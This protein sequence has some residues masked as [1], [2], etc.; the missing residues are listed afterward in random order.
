MVGTEDVT[1]AGGT[2]T[3]ATKD[4]GTGKTVTGTGFA[5]GGDDKGNYSLQSS[6]L[7]T[8]ADITAQGLTGHFT[9]ADKVY[10]GNRDA[11]ITGRTLTGVVG[12]EDVTLAGGTATFATKDVGTGKTVTGTGFA[13]GGDDKGNYSLASSTLTTEAEHH[14]QGADRPLHGGRQGLRRQPRRHHHRSHAD[15]RG[16]HEDVTL[17]GGTAT[18]AT[19]DVGTGKTVTGTE[20]RAGRRRRG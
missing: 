3:F 16:R 4:V 18:F 15:R 11:T 8:E 5:L 20:L 2:A 1:L 7:T 12:T 6:T 10:D 19:K 17:A 13:L 14:G 9:A